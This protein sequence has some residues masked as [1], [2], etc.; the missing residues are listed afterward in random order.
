MS[1]AVVARLCRE[2]A[3]KERR[4]STQAGQLQELAATRQNLANTKQQ[5]RALQ[6]TLQVIG[7]TKL[8]TVTQL[9]YL[10]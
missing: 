10:N 7:L 1:Q 8:C 5:L 3:D 6:L 2:A 4:L 9:V